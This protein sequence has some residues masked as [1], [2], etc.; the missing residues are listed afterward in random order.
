VALPTGGPLAGRVAAVAAV[1]GPRKQAAPGT[2]AAL[3]GPLFRMLAPTGALHW[4]FDH[5]R[6]VNTFTTNLRG[7]AEPLRFA[8]APVQ[9]VIPVPATTGNVPVTFAVLSYV[10][11]LWLTVLSDPAR[12]PDV[13]VLTAALR[14]DLPPAAG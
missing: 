4:Y 13:A 14:G 12:L 10:G 8:G 7:P 2:S 1:T 11:T 9:A 6:R 5:Q 3:L